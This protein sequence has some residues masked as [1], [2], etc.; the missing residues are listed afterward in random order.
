MIGLPAIRFIPKETHHDAEGSTNEFT[1]QLN[2]GDPASNTPKN[3]KA[4]DES[5]DE[6][7]KPHGDTKFREKVIN[8]CEGDAEVFI[9]W[10]KQLDTVMK[11]KSCESSKSKLSIVSA[12]LYGDLAD[13]WSEYVTTI[14]REMRTKKKIDGAGM[15]TEVKRKEDKLKPPSRC[16]WEDSMK[17]F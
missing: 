2:L 6:D 10:N 3:R 13:T 7:Q 8:L 15:E 12:M 5:E 17:A 14:T 11:D 9:R 4:E 1:V 16:S